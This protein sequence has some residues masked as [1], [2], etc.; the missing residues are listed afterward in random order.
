MVGC[1]ISALMDVYIADL[2]QL[3]PYLGLVSASLQL[4]PSMEKPLEPPRGFVRVMIFESTARSALEPMARMGIS[5][6]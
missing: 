6:R 3:T 4:A 2:S 1:P 5:L